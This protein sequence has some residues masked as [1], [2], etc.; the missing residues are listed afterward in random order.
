MTTNNPP[1]AAREHAFA[2]S[3]GRTIGYGLY[4]AGDGALVVVLDGPGSRGLGRAMASSADR[5]GLTLLVPDRPGFGDS[6]QTSK[7]SYAATADDLLAVIERAGFQ[8]FGIVAQSGGT[9]YG[10]A[11]ASAAANR[12]TGIAF[13]GALGP[14]RDRDGLADVTGPMRTVFVLARHAPWLLRPLFGVFAHQARKD[15]HAAARR[16]AERVPSADRAVLEDPV[17]WSIHA[18]SSAEILSRPGA[19]ARETRMLAQPWEV[20]RSRVTAPAA[21]WAGELDEAHPPSMSRRLAGLLGGAP[22]T[23]VAGAGVFA[24]SAHYP[25]ALRHAAALPDEGGSPLAAH[26]ASK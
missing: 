11:L 1:R 19:V 2:V 17:N 14:L 21:F 4:G 7:G 9:P 6:T 23:V 24:L 22:V 20:D 12:A 15:P 18:T 8:R 10:L 25:D 13:V 3:D 16:Y 26:A 5:L